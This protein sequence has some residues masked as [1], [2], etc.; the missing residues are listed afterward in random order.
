VYCVGILF[1]IIGIGVRGIIDY[2]DIM[3]VSRVEC[4]AF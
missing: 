2:E 3:Y 1:Y 4:Y